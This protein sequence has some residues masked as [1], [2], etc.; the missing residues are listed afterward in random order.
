MRVKVKRCTVEK[1]YYDKVHSEFFQWLLLS[2]FPQL[3]LEVGGLCSEKDCSQKK[4]L[5]TLT[6][7]NLKDV[8]TALRT[9]GPERLTTSHTR[10]FQSDFSASS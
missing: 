5:W 8:G 3:C 10:N 2:L 6:F 1:R 4:A 7:E 9:S